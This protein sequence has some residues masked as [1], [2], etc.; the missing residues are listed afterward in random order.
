MME[1]LRKITPE[2]MSFFD[3]ILYAS[4]PA[5]SF[6]PQYRMMAREISEAAKGTILDIG[7]GPGVLPLEIGKAL[8]STRIIGIDLSAKMIKIA[9][10]NKKKHGLTNIDFAVMNARVLAF[11][12]NTLDMIISTDS[13]H[14]W[15]RPGAVLDEIYRCLKPGCEAWI[16]DGFSGASNEDIDTYIA[17]TG[18]IFSP[19]WLIR[20]ILGIH[21]FSQEEYNTT[22][23]NIVAE[24]HFKT[25]VCEKRGVMMRLRLRK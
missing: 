17:G 14:H 8:K 25:C 20:L 22:I 18:I 2:K 1:I 16:Y 3:A 12:D 5:K 10:R 23:N 21:G 24:T 15:K 9:Q 6:L 4:G 19:H 11:G 7:T 13:L